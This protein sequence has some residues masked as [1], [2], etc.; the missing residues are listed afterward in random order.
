MNILNEAK[1]FKV[2]PLKGLP[3]NKKPLIELIKVDAEDSIRIHEYAY[4]DRI[5]RNTFFKPGQKN[6]LSHFELRDYS[7]LSSKSYLCTSDITK[8][9][10]PEHMVCG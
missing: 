6:L 4:F 5:Y 7:G 3:L 2:L 9:H 10:I 1:N 8:I